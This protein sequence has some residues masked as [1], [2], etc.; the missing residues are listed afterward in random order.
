NAGQ[1]LFAQ[2]SV[3]AGVILL[4]TGVW[5]FLSTIVVDNPNPVAWSRTIH[6]LFAGLVLAG[7]IIHVYM[8]AI[9]RDGRPALKSMFSAM[10]LKNMPSI[11]MS[12]GIRN[13]TRGLISNLQEGASMRISTF[14]RFWPGLLLALALFLAAGCA[15]QASE[16]GTAYAPGDKIPEVE[17]KTDVPNPFHTFVDTDFVKGIV[18]DNM[19]REEP[20]DDVLLIDSRP[21]RSRYDWG[22]IPTAISLPDSDFEE[23]KDILPEDKS[24]LLV[25]HCM[26]PT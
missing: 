4:G 19:L 14:R 17:A 12:S 21:K 25:F 16:A 3:L 20:R 18:C 13:W 2:L 8:A 5:M 23:K 7:L 22:H 26:N 6:Y 9:S 24:T 11:T 1:K 15:K 10:C